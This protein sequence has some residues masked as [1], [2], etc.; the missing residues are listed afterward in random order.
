MGTMFG[1]VSAA[2]LTPVHGG[3]GGTEM[4]AAPGVVSP[5]RVLRTLGDVRATTVLCVAMPSINSPPLTLA[6]P[7]KPYPTAVAQSRLC[8]F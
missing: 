8:L 4:P 1:F 3:E 7:S 2:L 5:P 6:R